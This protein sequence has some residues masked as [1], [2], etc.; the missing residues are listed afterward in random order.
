VKNIINQNIISLDPGGKTG[1]YY[2]NGQEEKFIE[3]NKP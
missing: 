3:I 2:R 1:V